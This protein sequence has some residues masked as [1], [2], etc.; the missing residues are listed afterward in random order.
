MPLPTWTRHPCIYMQKICTNS[1]LICKLCK[2]MH[3]PL[4]WSSLESVAAVAI[5]ATSS[6]S[7][8]NQSSDIADISESLSVIFE[9]SKL[10]W[11]S[12]PWRHVSYNC[13]EGVWPD[14]AFQLPVIWNLGA[15]EFIYEFMKHMYEKIIWIHSL[16]VWIHVCEFIYIWIHIIIVWIHIWNEYMN[17]WVYEFMCMN[18]NVWILNLSMIH[19][20]MNSDI[21]IRCIQ[22]E[23]M[24]LISLLWIHNMNS[25][26]KID[27]NSMFWIHD[28]EFSS[29]IW[30]MAM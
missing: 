8:T 26:L 22:Y 12:L 19:K 2:S 7:L 24:K 13:S 29:E 15:P 10:R 20:Y 4:C 3:S 30:H 18:S 6:S 5:S 28:V 17:S 27:E 16:H 9:S 14:L 1:I 25:F 21:R 23:F 11:L